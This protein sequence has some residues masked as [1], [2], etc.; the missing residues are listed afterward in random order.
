V[1]VHASTE[2][3]RIWIARGA[4]PYSC[5]TTASPSVAFEL[6]GEIPDAVRAGLQPH[7]HVGAAQSTGVGGGF[8]LVFVPG[9]DAAAVS[10]TP[11]STKRVVPRLRA[12]AAWTRRGRSSRAD[13][14]AGA[15]P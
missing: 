4:D 2:V 6:V 10:V 9:C 8:R 12:A 11:P 7:D 13:R 15:V 1:F 14:G 3:W 5:I